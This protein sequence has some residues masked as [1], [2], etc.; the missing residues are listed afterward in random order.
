MNSKPNFYRGA[1]RI[2]QASFKAH[3]NANK[4]RIFCQEPSCSRLANFVWPRASLPKTTKDKPAYCCTP[5]I[6]GKKIFLRTPKCHLRRSWSHDPEN[7]KS[8]PMVR[9]CECRADEKPSLILGR[10]H[11]SWMILSLIAL[12]KQKQLTKPSQRESQPAS[13]L[14]ACLFQDCLSRRNSGSAE[15]SQFFCCQWE[16]GPQETTR[17]NKILFYRTSTYVLGNMPSTD[18]L[19]D[20]SKWIILLI[21]WN[22]IGW[23]ILANF[24]V[25]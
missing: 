24:V 1:T 13:Q 19:R 18:V 11:I 25:K 15:V 6:N 14:L 16:M 7:S 5:I 12:T 9:A 2:Q 22:A 4:L 20:E 8:K 3:K 10:G 21:A 17:K 23:E